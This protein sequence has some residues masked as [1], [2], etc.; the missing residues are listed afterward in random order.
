MARRR[1]LFKSEPEEY[2]WDRLV[3]D[4]STA[5]TGVRNFQARNYLREAKAGDEVFFY[6]SNADPRAIMGIARVKKEAYTDEDDPQWVVVDIEPVGA[7]ARPVTLDEMK[8]VPE[9][10][11]MVL[12]RKGNRLSISPV[13][14]EEWKAVLKLSKS[15]AR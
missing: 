7:L 4:G 10:S 9:L 1:W 14:A 13:T 5:W 12:L 3:E 11:E 6:H 8:E 2:G 15:R